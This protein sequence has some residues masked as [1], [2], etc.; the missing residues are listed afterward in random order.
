M[1]THIYIIHII[2]N[3]SPLIDAFLQEHCSVADNV[4]WFK[5]IHVNEIMYLVLIDAHRHK[6]IGSIACKSIEIFV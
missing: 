1:E 2:G 5:N 6:K 3:F 4:F